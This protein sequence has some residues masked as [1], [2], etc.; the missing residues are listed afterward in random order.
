MGASGLDVVVVGGGIGGLTAALLLGRA[1]AAV[2]LLER[3]AEPAAVGAGILLQAN[4]L[5][6]LDGLGLRAPLAAAGHHPLAPTLRSASGR[7]ISALGPPA[8]GGMLAIRRSHLHRILLDAVEDRPGIAVRLDARV[9][10]ARPDGTVE[11]RWRGLDSSIAA[12]LVVGADGVDSTVRSGGAFGARLTATG[13]RYVRGLVA[14]GPGPELEGEY[15][16]RLGLFGGAPVDEATTYF[17]AAAT[18]PP[19]AAAIAARDLAAFRRAWSDAL[20]AAAAVLDRVGGFEE[21]LVNEVVRV[22]CR[23]WWDGRLVL[24]GDAA[25]A[26]APTLG[27]G[28]NSALVDGAVL[29]AE[30]ADDRPLAGAL[31]RYQARRQVAVRRVQ[32]R[33]DQLARLSGLASPALGLARDAL[34]R[35]AARTPGAAGRLDR[36]VQQ[37]DPAELARTVR[38]LPATP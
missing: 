14:R 3:V 1:G 37:E 38:R 33:A 31:D 4:G 5:A 30:L 23:R 36:L 15:W 19:V 17:Y 32:D 24:C 16:S 26:M 25:H 18:A 34:L 21:L 2:T 7:P 12:H 9:T 27:Q 29:A 10:A 13:A 28:A 35:L 8:P 6:V 22:D 11:L 20:P